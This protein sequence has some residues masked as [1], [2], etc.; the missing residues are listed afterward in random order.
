MLRLLVLLSFSLPLPPVSCISLSPFNLLITDESRRSDKRVKQLKEC[1]EQ[2]EH[3]EINV[4]TYCM[5]RKG[6][7]ESWLPSGLQLL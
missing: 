5:Q 1:K 7:R 3:R 6:E 2:N 4:H